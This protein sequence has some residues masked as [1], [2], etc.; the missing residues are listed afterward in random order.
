VLGKLREVEALAA[1]GE[2]AID[3]GSGGHP[4]APGGTDA[5]DLDEIEEL[6]PEELVELDANSQP[7]QAPRKR[8][9]TVMLEKPVDEGDVDT[10][11]DLGLACA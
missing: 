11:Y 7:I 6:A 3:V 10:H 4:A 8:Q 9:P 5:L 1:G 2:V